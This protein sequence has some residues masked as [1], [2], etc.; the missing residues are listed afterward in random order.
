VKITIIEGQ[1]LKYL[2]DVLGASNKGIYRVR[3]SQAQDA[4]RVIVKVN[5]GTWTAPIGQAD[6]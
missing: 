5:E 2:L 4:S 3:I 6:R 1:D